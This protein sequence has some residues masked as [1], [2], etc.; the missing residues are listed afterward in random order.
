MSISSQR[1]PSRL[2]EDWDAL[3]AREV[4]R[5]KQIEA[6]FDRV[7][8]CERAGQFQ[9]A[10]EWLDLAGEMSGGLSR[11]CRAQRARLVRAVDGENR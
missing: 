4:A 10:L 11:A 7:D 6:V 8:A 3:V 5:Q 1:Q 2:A 9:P